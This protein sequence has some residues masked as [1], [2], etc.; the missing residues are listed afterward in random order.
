MKKIRCIL[1][2]ALALL[3]AAVCLMLG[4]QAVSLYRIGNR[5]ENFSAPGVR[6]DPV[7]S[8]DRAAAALAP[9][10]PVFLV[11]L[12]VLILA[13]ILRAG[14]EPGP[15]VPLRFPPNA[16]R[17]EKDGGTFAPR[18][19]A[20]L[21]VLAGALIVLGVVNGGLYDVLVKAINICTEC[22]GLG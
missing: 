19:R 21:Y 20:I 16:A 13:L 12:A 5:P 9:V 3:W 2:W 15:I 10:L 11:F 1:P 22:I 6:I 18:L 8:R 7:F 4:W 17:A 14:R